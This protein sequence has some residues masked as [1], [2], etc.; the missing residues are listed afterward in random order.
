MSK[1]SKNRPQPS[2]VKPKATTADAL[3]SSARVSSQAR[4]EAVFSKDTTEIPESSQTGFAL[5]RFD[6]RTKWYLGLVTGL[7]LLLSLL[8]IHTLSVAMWNQLIPDGSDARRGIISGTP[9]Q[10]RMD[11]YAVWVPNT[12]SNVNKGYPVVNETLG[13]EKI[14]LLGAPAKHALMVFKPSLWGHFFLGAEQAIAWQSNFSY[15]VVLLFAFLLFM[16]LTENNFLLSVFG[17][18]WFWLSS[19]SQNWN[20]GCDTAIGMFSLLFVSGA[21]ILFGNQKLLGKIGWGVLLAWALFSSAILVYPPY[22]V[23]LGYTFLI[24]FIT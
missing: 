4:T 20:G 3:E 21:Y 18:V 9:Q 7:F 22:Q 2:V 19:A 12:L 8:K 17:S 23:P 5:I 15:F 10:I 24:L 11:E 16:L 6:R 14:A 1:P 13:G